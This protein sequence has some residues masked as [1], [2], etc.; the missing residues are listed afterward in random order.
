MR[1]QIIINFKKPKNNSLCDKME[2]SRYG[3]LKATR[4]WPTRDLIR[5][6]HKGGDL[7]VGF[8]AFGPSAYGKNLKQMSETYVHS[9]KYPEIS[10]RGPTTSES[11]SVCLYY[12]ENL[13]DKK[14]FMKNIS[15]SDK[16]TYDPQE[17]YPGRAKIFLDPDEPLDPSSYLF[18]LERAGCCLPDLFL[19]TTYRL[20]L[21]WMAKTSEGVFTNPPKDEQ[22]K[23]VTDE[24]VLRRLLRRARKSNGIYFCKNNVSFVPYETYE[25]DQTQDRATFAR[26]GLARALEHT[27]DEMAEK[28]LKI[29]S[30]DLYSSKPFNPESVR[31]NLGKYQNPDP[32]AA[33]I[34]IGHRS[35]VFEGSWDFWAERMTQDQGYAFGVFDPSADPSETK[36]PPEPKKKRFLSRLW[37]RS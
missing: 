26:S 18:N 25:H 4:F 14:A 21:G 13:F 9:E 22:G 17:L 5:V 20:Q 27:G 30:S 7:I 37:K 8:P 10:F 28:L 6:P 31:I 15:L 23:P 33:V 34:Y 36:K 32:E 3:I 16:I 35:F 1:I 11:I 29:F 2:E 24:K 19:Y 12:V